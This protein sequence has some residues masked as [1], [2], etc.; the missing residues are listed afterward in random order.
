MLMKQEYIVYMGSLPES[1]YLPS[2]HHLSMLQEVVQARLKYFSNFKI[3]TS[4][5]ILV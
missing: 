5:T 3:C 4:F 2:S 1:E